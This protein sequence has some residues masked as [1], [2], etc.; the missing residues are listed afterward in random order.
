MKVIAVILVLILAA[1]IGVFLFKVGLIPS[2]KSL[3]GG[4]GAFNL[5]NFYGG[6][7]STSTAT[8]AANNPPWQP[9]P[10]TS[11]N[12]QIG[13]NATTTIDPS[14]IPAGFTVSQLS[15]Y[16]HKIRI[17]SVYPGYG[18]GNVSQISLSVSLAAN[19]ALDITGW[20]MQAN[21]G[22]QYIPKGV[23]VYDPSGLA[24]DEDIYARDGETVTV[25]SSVSRI[26]EN[27]RMNKCIGYIEQ[28]QGTFNPPLGQN[29]P[30]IDRSEIQSFTGQCQ[31]YIMSL[32][33]CALPNSNPPI[34]S[35]DY[36]CQTFLNTLNYGGC[37]AR[38]R[39][40]PD[41]LGRE[42][43]IWTGT[44]FLDASHDRVLLFDRN[45]L[46]VDEYDY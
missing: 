12:N 38:H 35:T 18:I 9:T 25:Y 42:W 23:E 1:I 14:Q 16:F 29:C 15:P 36:G 32:G 37:F 2:G 40:D 21:R 10:D 8:A 46:L 31:N 22:S 34:P 33:N 27:F 41:F 6:G 19:E 20:R 13:V 30:Y 4:G 28:T 24:S 39:A 17:T 45:G 43:R 3:S 11:S 26:G 5:P 44:K 7:S